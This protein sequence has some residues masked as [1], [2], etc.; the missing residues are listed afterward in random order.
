MLVVCPGCSHLA[1][2]CA[3]EGSAYPSAKRIARFL[4]VNPQAVHCPVCHGPILSEFR[5]AT[6]DE[7]RFAGLGR[8]DYE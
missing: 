5:V 1:A 4:A 6:S 3:E 7:I 8:S 2:I